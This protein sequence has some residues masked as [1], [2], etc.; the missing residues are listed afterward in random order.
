MPG[1][2]LNTAA[3]VICPHG[4]QAQPVQPSPFVRVGGAAALTQPAGHTVAGCALPPPA[5]GPCATVQWTTAA[6]TVF[7]AGQPLL[8]ADSASLCLPPSAPAQVPA[9]QILVRGK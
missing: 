7:S 3:V 8:L 5:G 2:L 6:L 1:F 4:G 9:T